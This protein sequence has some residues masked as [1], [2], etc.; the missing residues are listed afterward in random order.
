MSLFSPA[1]L[2]RLM[3]SKLSDFFFL[4][5]SRMTGDEI[6]GIKIESTLIQANA[7]ALENRDD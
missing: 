7:N 4:N 1:N 6:K 2:T 5:M 3:K